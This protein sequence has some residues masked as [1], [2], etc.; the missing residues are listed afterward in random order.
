MQN[1][2]V[3]FTFSVFDRKNPFWANLDQKSQNYQF[4]LKFGTQTNSNMQ[5]SIV[6][7]TFFVFDQ[8]CPFW[9]NLVQNVKTI[10]LRLNL[11][12]TIAHK[13]F[14]TNSSFHVKQ[15]T[16][17]NFG[18]CFSRIFCQYYQNFHFSGRLVTRLSFYEAQTLF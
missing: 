4:K 16:T 14:E 11:V 15:R 10:S 1:S 7:F 2:M 8:K 5:Y 6:V 9:A 18:F 12:A 17:G 3:M 13:V